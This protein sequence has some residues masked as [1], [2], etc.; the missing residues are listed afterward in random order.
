MNK[1]LSYYSWIRKLIQEDVPA[2]QENLA[3]NIMLVI[4]RMTGDPPNTIELERF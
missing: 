1:L 4:L 3:R 2:S